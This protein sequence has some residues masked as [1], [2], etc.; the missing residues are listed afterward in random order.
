MYKLKVIRDEYPADPRE[1]DNL[2][3]M[4]CFHR[5]YDLGDE[6]PRCDPQEWLR[7]LACSL[8]NSL[9][10]R[11]DYW[12]NGSSCKM[13]SAAVDAKIEA[14]IWR[15]LDARAVVLP[16]YLYDHGGLSMSVGAFSCP[17]DSGQVGWIYASREDVLKNYG[18]KR[19]TAALRERAVL[20]LKG[21]VETYDQFLSGDVWGWAVYE[22][23]EECDCEPDEECNCTR[24][25]TH[26][27]SCWGCYGVAEALSEGQAHLGWLEKNK[28]GE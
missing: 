3:K 18:G 28:G 24:G 15:V 9:A 20:L 2:G 22:T 11:L 14:A 10:E 16:L 19:L 25:A 13:S 12:E 8:D 17:W 6:Q 4:V 21:E 23:D 5:R 27:D 1:W 26:V 7:S